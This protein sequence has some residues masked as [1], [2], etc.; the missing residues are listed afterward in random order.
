[1]P[2]VIPPW[3]TFR[4]V[5]SDRKTSGWKKDVGRVFRIGYY[6]GQDG[7][8]VIWL[9]NEKGEYEQTTDRNFL[10]EYF[11]P[12]EISDERDFWGANKAKFKP[13]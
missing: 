5:R 4:L 11:E 9:V 3:S 10:V 1:M 6:G 7:L 8:E 2:K 13:L 12:M